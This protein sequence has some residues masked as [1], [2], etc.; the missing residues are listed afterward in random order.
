MEVDCI[1]ISHGRMVSPSYF[2]ELMVEYKTNQPSSSVETD[3]S[4]INMIGIY[5]KV[6]SIVRYNHEIANVPIPS[7]LHMDAWTI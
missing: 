4:N 7:G 3:R 6:F 2:P 5:N 1:F